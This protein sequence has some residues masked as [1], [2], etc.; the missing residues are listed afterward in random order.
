[1]IKPKGAPAKPRPSKPR[2][3]KGYVVP[4]HSLFR[5]K[6]L[7]RP[8]VAPP[9]KKG[10]TQVYPYKYVDEDEQRDGMTRRTLT[11]LVAK[12][13]VVDYTTYKKTPKTTTKGD[14]FNKYNRS[15]PGEISKVSKRVKTV[16]PATGSGVK[17]GTPMRPVTNR[18]K[19]K[20]H[21]GRVKA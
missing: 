15:G 18:S 20:P 21:Q 11:R 10:R 12:K 1:M 7:W 19:P 4:K 8:Y 14:F 9:V 3:S 17:K 2:P 5:K 13:G 6:D 16:R